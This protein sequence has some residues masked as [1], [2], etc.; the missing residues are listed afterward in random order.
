MEVM[1]HERETSVLRRKTEA[2][3]TGAGTAPITPARAVTL[4][5]S[6]VAQDRLDLPLQVTAIEEA[7]RSLADL[8]EMLEDLS[9]LAV[10]EGPAEALGVLALPPATLATLIE[11]QTMGRFGK[12]MPAPRKPTRIDAAIA[13]DFV[14]AVLAEIEEALISEP[15]ISWAGGFRF[16]SH[17]DDPRP[18]GLLLEDVSYRVWTAELSFGATGE[19][20]GGFL[21]AVPR[22]G[23]GAA[24][25]RVA[26]ATLEDAKGTASPEAAF[27]PDDPARDWSAT[28]ERSILAASAQLEA[29]LHRVTLP[30]SAVL[31]LRQGSE[32][33]IPQE[34]L[35]RIALEAEGRRKLS[36]AR[37]GQSHGM[38]ALRLCDAEAAGAA[39]AQG[40]GA[41]DAGVSPYAEAP[42]PDDLP[43]LSRLGDPLDPAY[44]AE[45]GGHAVHAPDP[46]GLV[47]LGPDMDFGEPL[48]LDTLAP[49]QDEEELTPLK[50]QSGL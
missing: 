35:E 7:M 10:I 34:A 50:I 22:E 47:G 5:L 12:T 32:I 31:T 24:M 19:R 45:E 23:R 33:P 40:V 25:R 26:P 49:S 48:D 41:F 29:V 11:M 1:V 15:A 17:L 4:A 43:G 9:L 2:A 30:L 18:L 21:W 42:T 36:L 8:P 46:R 6:K 13:A 20:S 3:K 28:F 38:R 16:A 37:L 27:V 44:D 39:G 14:D